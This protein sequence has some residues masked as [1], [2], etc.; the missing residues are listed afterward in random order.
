M[1]VRI[2]ANY[3]TL[4]PQEARAADFILDHLDDLAVYSATE[5]ASS[6]G[7][8]KATVSRLFRRLGFADAQEVREHARELRLRGVPVGAPGSLAAHA[9]AEHEALERMLAGLGDGLLEAAAGVVSAAAEVVVAG[10]RN[11]YP[12]ALHLRE[13]LAQARGAVRIAP[14]P[15]QSVGEELAGLGPSDAV[16]LIGFRRRPAGFDAVLASLGTRGVPVVLVV[17]PGWRGAAPAGTVVLT[18]PVD[19]VGA[20]D[21][22]ASAMSLANLLATRVLARQGSAGRARVAAITALYGELGELE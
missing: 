10:F 16:V 12:V 22:Y 8:S 15:G 4:T 18:C 17:E 6:S 11:S 19:A 13:Q 5:I 1:R 9:A 2:D 21:S 20:F 14:A 7:V 3:G